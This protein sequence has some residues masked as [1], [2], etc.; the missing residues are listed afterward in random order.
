MIV[1]LLKQVVGVAIKERN[2]YGSFSFNKFC[3]GVYEWCDIPRWQAV[4]SLA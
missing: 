3:D 4:A 2:V 1:G